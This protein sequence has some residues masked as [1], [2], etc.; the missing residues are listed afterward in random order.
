MTDGSMPARATARPLCVLV[1]PDSFKG[2]FSSVVV[3][4]ALAEGWQRRAPR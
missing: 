3:A 1:A 2:T 4:H